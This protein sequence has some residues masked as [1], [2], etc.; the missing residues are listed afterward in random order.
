MRYAGNLWRRVL[1]ISGQL[2]GYIAARRGIIDVKVR[3]Q[4]SRVNVSV[5]SFFPNSHLS[6]ADMI[7]FPHCALQHRAVFTPALMF[8]KVAF[9]LTPEILSQLW[10]EQYSPFLVIRT[11]AMTVPQ[12]T[13]N[14]SFP[15][16]AAH[17]D[18]GRLLDS[19]LR[20]SR[21]S[22]GIRNVLRTVKDPAQPIDSRHNFHDSNTLPIALMQTMS[23]ALSLKWKEDDTAEKKGP[24]NISSYAPSLA[25]FCVARQHKDNH[26]SPTGEANA[27]SDPSRCTI[28][29]PEG[30]LLS[31]LHREVGPNYL[32][33]ITPHSAVFNGDLEAPTP[34][35]S[36]R[37]TE[38]QKECLIESKVGFLGPERSKESFPER[39]GPAYA[40]GSVN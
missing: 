11:I 38:F 21:C 35:P 20:I 29:R 27:D 39:T 24:S 14:E 26:Q 33:P 17:S 12:V 5:I 37:Q 40:E 3:R 13:N 8:S 19:K 25:P 18:T 7:P 16:H 34:P 9:S 31:R 1:I 4:M 6:G 32:G 28:S 22:M 15:L 36:A 2:I 10:G 30:I 23:G